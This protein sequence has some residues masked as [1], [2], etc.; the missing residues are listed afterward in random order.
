MF[1]L[2]CAS[3]CVRTRC[4]VGRDEE[5]A[6]TLL[7]QM[8]MNIYD[9][10][11]VRMHRLSVSQWEVKIWLDCDGQA[12]G[13]WRVV[14]TNITG[15]TCTVDVSYPSYCCTNLL[16]EQKHLRF[17]NIFIEKIKNSSQIS[18]LKKGKNSS[19]IS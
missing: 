11:G 9:Y 8:F 17:S 1:T 13:A 16:R 3:H 15:H 4:D 19:Q 5:T 6:C 2:V 12:N 18:L 14:I 10:V 7:K